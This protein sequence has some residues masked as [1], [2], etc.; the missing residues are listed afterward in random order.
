M[1]T[2]GKGTHGWVV[3]A[4]CFVGVIFKPTNPV[5]WE[6]PGLMVAKSGARTQ[7]SFPSYPPPAPSLALRVQVT[8]Q[9][10]E[11]SRGAHVICHGNQMG[12]G[13]GWAWT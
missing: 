8:L 10:S 11:S 12:V 5:A 6:V 7:V 4:L 9:L 13:K 3:L 2:G 1:A